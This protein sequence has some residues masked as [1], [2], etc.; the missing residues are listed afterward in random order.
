MST[1]VPIMGSSCGCTDCPCCVTAFKFINPAA[2]PAAEGVNVTVTF[3]GPEALKVEGLRV[4]AL[5][6]EL[7]LKI[8][9]VAGKSVNVW[10]EA[11]PRST[12]PKLKELGEKV[13]AARPV[14]L[15]ATVRDVV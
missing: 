6:V 3:M 5:L 15:T 1:P 10:D 8:R 7:R 14:P 12:F 13:K 4:K 2:A 9:G 11:H